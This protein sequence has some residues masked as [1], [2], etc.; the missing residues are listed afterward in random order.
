MAKSTMTTSIMGRRMSAPFLSKKVEPSQLPA[1]LKA[2]AASPSGMST[3]PLTR[4][5]ARAATLV[6]R[7]IALV[8][9]GGRAHV[10]VGHGSEQ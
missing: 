1:I 2:A 4:N 3:A 8:V 5:T 6:A 9:P 10:L 7:L